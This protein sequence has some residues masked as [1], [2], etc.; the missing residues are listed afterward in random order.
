MA[1]SLDEIIDHADELADRFEAG[2]DSDP[3]SAEPLQELA[4]A[5]EGRGRAEQRV[6]DAVRG[7]RHDGLPWGVI[8]LAL[9]TSGEA[10]RQR[11]GSRVGPP[12]G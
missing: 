6:I 3:R 9:G 1:R 5:A 8:G 7:A 4:R 10:A 12:A 11:Y 2:L